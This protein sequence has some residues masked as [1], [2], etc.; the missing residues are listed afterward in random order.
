MEWLSLINILLMLCSIVLAWKLSKKPRK[1]VQWS[2]AIFMTLAFLSFLIFSGAAHRPGAWAWLVIGAAAGVAAGAKS[3]IYKNGTFVCYVQSR[4][5]TLLYLCLL[6]TN[7]FIA[8]FAKGYIPFMLFLSATALGLQLGLNTYIL[9]RSRKIKRVSACVILLC[10]LFAAPFNTPKMF[11]A[12]AYDYDAALEEYASYLD[13]KDKVGDTWYSVDNT[14][15]MFEAEWVKKPFIK[16]GR[17]W[18]A[19]VLW[20]HRQKSD[21]STEKVLGALTGYNDAEHLE[22]IDTISVEELRALFPQFE[23]PEKSHQD[24][25]SADAS[26][27][28]AQGQTTKPADSRQKYEQINPSSSNERSGSNEVNEP[29]ARSDDSNNSGIIQDDSSDDD[30]DWF[31]LLPLSEEES[32]LAGGIGG[33]FGGIGGLLLSLTGFFRGGSI[34][35]APFSGGTAPISNPI[36]GVRR[37]DGK[38]YTPN[39]GWQDEFFPELQVNSL[40]NSIGNMEAK[41]ANYSEGSILY[42]VTRDMIREER[43]RLKQWTEDMS[44][45]KRTRAFEGQDMYQKQAARWNDRD[46]GLENAAEAAGIASLAGDLALAV[47]TSGTSYLYTGAKS[48]G[49]IRTALKTV[50]A[51]SKAKE[52]VGSAANIC[53]N[54][55]KD[56]N[57]AAAITGEGVNYGLGKGVGKLFDKGKELAGF[58][59]Y[60]AKKASDALKTFLAA[61]ETKGSN[62]AQNMAEDFGIT[63]GI[64]D[65]VKT[66]DEHFK[67]V[68][69]SMHDIADQGGGHND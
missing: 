43:L 2:I 20:L 14:P 58:H 56:K 22:P 4:A 27:G 52:A 45:I 57:L 24:I 31:V 37:A 9:A 67:A 28:D 62:A 41:M 18:L 49:S 11:A 26:S 69:K 32:D 30:Q 59:K 13:Q 47:A 42:E 46:A 15:C 40:R 34:P 51:L 65:A 12:D 29:A 21:G 53:D 35:S 55:L 39:H 8:A 25:P 16:D 63:G 38:I 64:T 33:L 54:Y 5:F 61:A 48:L 19:R 50:N 68:G 10:L 6:L 3:R 1:L 66:A 7:Q 17:V 44:M 60:G 36:P 23:A